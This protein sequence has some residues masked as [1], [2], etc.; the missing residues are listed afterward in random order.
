VRFTS[1]APNSSRSARTI[2]KGLIK[3][4]VREKMSM[5]SPDHGLNGSHEEKT[6]TVIIDFTV[7]P[8]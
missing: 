3:G 7:K 1:H 6:H 8:S 4:S 2:V 5:E